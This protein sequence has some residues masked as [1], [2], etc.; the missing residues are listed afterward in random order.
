LVAINYQDRK[1]PFLRACLTVPLSPLGSRGN[2]RDRKSPFLSAFHPVSRR[3]A[4]VLA[5]LEYVAVALGG[6]SRGSRTLN[7]ALEETASAP[8]RFS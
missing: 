7:C 1:S 8:R 4:H 5:E 3:L 2:Y 6:V